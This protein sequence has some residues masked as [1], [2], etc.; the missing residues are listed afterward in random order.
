M[1]L[2]KIA[3]KGT[4]Q[5]H[6][7]IE[8]IKEDIILLRDGSC[9]MVLQTSSVN[10]DLLSEKEQEAMIYAYAAIL[11]SLTFPIQLLVRSS[12]KDVSNYLNR[13]KRQ[14]VKINDPL[15]GKLIVSYRQFVEEM[16][17]KNNV[18]AKSFYIIVPFYAVE[19]GIGATAKA[20]FPSPISFL[21]K[22]TDKGLPADKEEILDKAKV[23]LLPKKDHLIRLF[24]RL[25]LT[26]KQLTT[27]ELIRL[28]Y[29][30]YN[31]ESVLGDD[32]VSFSKQGALI[33][34]KSKLNQDEIKHS[35][36]AQVEKELT[37]SEKRESPTSAES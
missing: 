6:L 31:Q 19:L 32:S 25:G 22:K 26:I 36:K 9:A 28:L 27:K 14:E 15:L 20:N 4:T 33:K 35:Q 17:K 34:R 12:L 16:V 37:G 5:E 11:N 30:I 3:I 10:F 1:D 7:P 2:N 23:A 29:R 24:S 13:L 21:T 8:D 18:L